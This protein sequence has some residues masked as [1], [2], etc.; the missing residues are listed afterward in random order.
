MNGVDH[1]MEQTEDGT[2]HLVVAATDTSLVDM[3]IATR[4]IHLHGFV[5]LREGDGHG[6]GHVH[7]VTTVIA[8]LLTEQS[9][10]ES[11]NLVDEVL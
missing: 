2:N 3:T 6:H 11:Q 1:G 8:C 4:L 7:L 5:K 9:E 10:G